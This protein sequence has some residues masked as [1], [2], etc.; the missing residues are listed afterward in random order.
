[1]EVPAPGGGPRQIWGDSRGTLWVS[2]AGGGRLSRFDPLGEAWS[3]WDI[4]GGQADAHALYVDEQERV[5][6][7]DYR[8]NAILR[9]NPFSRHFAS[10]PSDRPA[11]RVTQLS[12]RTGEVWGAESAQDRLVMIKY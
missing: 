9:F 1:M 7:S 4:P 12:G 2:E 6:L 8:A 10:F 3:S 5:W 11:A